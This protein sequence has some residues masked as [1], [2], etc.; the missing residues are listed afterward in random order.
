MFEVYSEILVKLFRRVEYITPSFFF[1]FTDRVGLESVLDVYLDMV[2]I[3]LMLDE[4]DLANI[5]FKFNVMEI[6][7]GVVLGQIIHWS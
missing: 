5:L 2:G 6:V 7:D 3:D 1:D 4:V